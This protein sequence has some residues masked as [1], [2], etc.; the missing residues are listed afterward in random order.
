M[1]Q[2]VFQVHDIDE[3]KQRLIDIL[4]GYKQSVIDDVV[5][6]WRKRLR[7]CIPVKEGL[8]DNPC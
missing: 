5:D 3:R 1:R 8:F 2:R 6:E 7:A 4:H